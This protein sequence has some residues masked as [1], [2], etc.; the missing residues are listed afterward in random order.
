MIMSFRIGFELE[1][2]INQL[3]ALKHYNRLG[4]ML[5]LVDLTHCLAK[6]KWYQ[7]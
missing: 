5:W 4:A 3:E 2:N 6:G 1:D 7:L